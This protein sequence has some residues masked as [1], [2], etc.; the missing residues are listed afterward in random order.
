MG[1]YQKHIHTVSQLLIL[2]LIIIIIHTN[3]IDDINTFVGVNYNMLTKRFTCTFM[4]KLDNSEKSCAITLYRDCQQQQLITAQVNSTN[5]EIVLVPDG[6]QTE[7]SVYCYVVV[8]RNDTI[9]LSINGTIGQSELSY[10]LK[11]L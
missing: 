4:N 7:T 5:S 9:T 3:F 11:Y 2:V 10:N 1:K 8:A 6:L